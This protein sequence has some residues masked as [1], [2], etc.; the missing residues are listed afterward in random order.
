M[1]GDI[2]SVYA[3]PLNRSEKKK[4]EI[5]EKFYTILDSILRNISNGQIVIIAGDFNAKTDSAARLFQYKL[6]T[7][8]ISIFGKNWDS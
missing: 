7:S 8:D 6:F 5:K 3:P 4:H 1:K 2:L